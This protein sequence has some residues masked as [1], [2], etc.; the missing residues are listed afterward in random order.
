MRILLCFLVLS[1]ASCASAPKMASP[2]YAG[3]WNV[4]VLNTPLG[5]VEGELVLTGT[6]DNL[7]G[8][9]VTPGATYPLKKALKTEKGLSLAFFFPDQGI[10]VNMELEGGPA[11]ES[12]LG[13]TL[14]EYRTTAIR[15]TPKAAQ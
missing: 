12:L 13:T 6:D 14:G 2:A 9:F 3:S 7:S 5:T 11:A 4:T 10:D 1:I 8:Q 15:A